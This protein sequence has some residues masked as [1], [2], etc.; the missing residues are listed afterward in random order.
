M[1]CYLLDLF[2]PQM[3]VL[4]FDLVDDVDAKIHVHRLVTQ[5]V[6]KLLGRAGHLVAAAH[7]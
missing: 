6:L 7:R 2:V 1:L 5:D 3:G 4:Q